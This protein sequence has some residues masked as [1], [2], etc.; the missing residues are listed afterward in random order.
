MEPLDAA[1]FGCSRRR[2]LEP[3]LK[4]SRCALICET[5]AGKV[6]GYGLLRDGSLASYLGPVVA[7]SHAAGV[8]LVKVLLSRAGERSVYWDIPDE[9]LAAIALARKFGLAAQR[10]LTRMYL[11]ENATPGDP[12][13]QIDIAGPEVG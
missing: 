3:L 11:G 4:Q 13:R 12:L 8:S 5:E 10:A 7:A 1:A 9:N 2:V 6:A